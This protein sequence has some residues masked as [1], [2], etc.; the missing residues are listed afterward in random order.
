MKYVAIIF[1]GIAIGLGAMMF[2]EYATS[3]K[4]AVLIGMVSVPL[5]AAMGHIVGSLFDGSRA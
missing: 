2:A 5:S 1:G 4:G 3:I